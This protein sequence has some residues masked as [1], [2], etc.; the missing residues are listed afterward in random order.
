MDRPKNNADF[1]LLPLDEQQAALA[2]A[3]STLL[4]GLEE[5]NEI[6]LLLKERRENRGYI[7]KRTISFKTSKSHIRRGVYARR[8]NGSKT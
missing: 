5:D 1:N 3:T 4:E 6:Q 8:L 2:A 7:P